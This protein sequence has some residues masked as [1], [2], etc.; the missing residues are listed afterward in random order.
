MA[1]YF[2]ADRKPAIFQFAVEGPPM[3]KI[4]THVGR[5]RLEATAGPAKGFSFSHYFGK[6]AGG[7]W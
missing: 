3:L 6:E 1:G 5:T 7:T 4:E 2:V